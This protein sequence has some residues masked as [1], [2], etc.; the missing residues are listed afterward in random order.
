MLATIIL[1]FLVLD[2]MWI[3]HSF[4]TAPMVD[5][6]DYMSYFGEDVNFP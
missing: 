6:E 4:I 5:D 3:T 1:V 2:I